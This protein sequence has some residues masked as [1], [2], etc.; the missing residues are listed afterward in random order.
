MSRTSLVPATE[1]PLG[2]IFK[3]FFLKPAN[4]LTSS[5]WGEA[6]FRYERDGVIGHRFEYGQFKGAVTHVLR[7]IPIELHE[8]GLTA[9]IEQRLGALSAMAADTLSIYKTFNDGTIIL[10]DLR[11]SSIKYAKYRIEGE[12][13][14]IPN[15][16][17][18]RFRVGI[19][20]EF[21]RIVTP[22]IGL[23]T[24]SYNIDRDVV[25]WAR[26]LGAVKFPTAP[27]RYGVLANGSSV[28]MVDQPNTFVYRIV[29]ALDGGLTAQNVIETIMSEL[30][31]YLVL[32]NWDMVRV[33]EFVA[34]R[35]L[36]MNAL[37]NR[38]SLGRCAMYVK[39]IADDTYVFGYVTPTVA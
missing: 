5:I 36:G 25:D 34:T 37:D 7:A 16:M 33:I 13:A 21:G 4:T 3:G 35:Q 23:L 15:N 30:E 11:W 17:L 39:C 12:L 10:L 38:L 29:T 22:A 31:P 26:S 14:I 8:P 32:A 18:E 24:A 28:V 20:R 1:R 6:Q 2:R 19:D 27:E 9:F